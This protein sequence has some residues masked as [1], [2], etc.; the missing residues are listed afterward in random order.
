MLFLSG[1]IIKS[2]AFSIWVDYKII[3]YLFPFHSYGH[4]EPS[5]LTT[6]PVLTKHSPQEIT[7]KH[8]YKKKQ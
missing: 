2:L 8:T 3:I 1:L 6:S 5:S 4:R 7:P